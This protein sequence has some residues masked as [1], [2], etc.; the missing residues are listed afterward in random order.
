MPIIVELQRYDGSFNS[1]ISE[2]VDFEEEMLFDYAP[3]ILKDFGSEAK[4]LSFIYTW[5]GLY[6]IKEKLY[7]HKEELSLISEKAEMFLDKVSKG[8]VEYVDINI[9]TLFKFKY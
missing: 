4:T 9:I 3:Q 2:L 6:I 7:N 5:I 1:T 8:T